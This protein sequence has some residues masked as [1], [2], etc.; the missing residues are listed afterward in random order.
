MKVAQ[1][2]CEVVF[3]PVSLGIFFVDSC[4]IGVKW[5]L[6]IVLM[7]IYLM[8]KDVKHFFMYLL[9][10]CTSFE[11]SLFN[12]VAC[13]LFELLALLMFNILVLYIF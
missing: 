8:T 4:L 3:F 7:C 2:G 11:N 12:S 1:A 9:A 5:N 10:I 6:C 13:I